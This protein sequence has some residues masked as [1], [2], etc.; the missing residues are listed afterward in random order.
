MAYV[1]ALAAASATPVINL[2][3]GGNLELYLERMVT[4]I[5]MEFPSDS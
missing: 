5:E 1:S 2:A 3:L 4:N